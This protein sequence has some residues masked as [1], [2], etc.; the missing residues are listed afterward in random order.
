M[1]KC[2]SNFYIFKIPLV[3]PVVDDGIHHG[4]GHGQPVE[5]QIHVLDIFGGDHLIIVIRVDE[6]QV[7]GKPAYGKN[8]DHRYEHSNYFALGFH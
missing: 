3:H 1:S 2:Q 8:R 6:E 7:I 4:I 5:T